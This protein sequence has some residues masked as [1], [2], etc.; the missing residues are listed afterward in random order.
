MCQFI[1]A[2]DGPQ[3]WVGDLVSP[4]GL[5]SIL[6]CATNSV[7]GLARSARARPDDAAFR[8]VGPPRAF[9]R[10]RHPRRSS[11]SSR[12]IEERTSRAHAAAPTADG[13]AG[14][15]QELVA[16]RFLP[17]GEPCGRQ[18]RSECIGVAHR[19]QCTARQH[20]KDEHVFPPSAFTAARPSARSVR[21]PRPTGSGT[22]RY[23]AAA[24]HPGSTRA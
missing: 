12:Y 9:L 1:S 5:L 13:E 2:V 22:A 7:P 8:S 15:D 20:S 10:R 11:H 14:Q 17:A 21:S 16:G 24:P 3:D 6:L 23:P 19:F 4:M 18:V